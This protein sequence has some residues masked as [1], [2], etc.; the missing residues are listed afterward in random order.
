M[1]RLF[2]SILLALALM[3]T[4]SAYAVRYGVKKQLYVGSAGANPSYLAYSRTS[5][6]MYCGNASAGT[7]SYIDCG[8]DT[9]L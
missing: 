9:L 6:M 4:V 5:N 8:L 7:V 1:K 2:V 3:P